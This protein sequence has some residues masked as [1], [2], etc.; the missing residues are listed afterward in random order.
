MFVHLPKKVAV[1]LAAMIITTMSLFIVSCQ[2]EL[3]GGGLIVTEEQPDLS[4]KIASSVSGF[5]TDE[6]DAAVQGATVQFGSNTA[7]TDK[8]GYFEFSNVQVVKNAAVVTV[9]KPG[10]F[11]G[12]K[13]YIAAENKSGFFR[14]KLLPKTTQGSFDA[15]A[16]GTVTLTNGL[17]IAFP[18]AAVKLAAGGTYT[19]QVNVAAQWINPAAN[20]L[21][22]IMPGDLRGLDTDGFLRTLTTYGMAAVELTGSAGELLQIADGKKATMTF[23]IPASLSGAAPAELPLWS[24]DETGGLWKQEGK[25]TKSGSNYV[26]EVSHFSFWNCDVPSNFVQFNCTIK[27]ADGSPVPY[28]LVKVSVVGTQSA[29]YGYTDSSGYTGGAVPNNA[30]LLLEVFPYFNCGTAVYSQNFTTTNTNI[31]LGDL[32]IP[33]SSLATAHVTGTV[34]NC[35]NAPVT[36]GYVIMYS[37]GQYSRYEVDNA[38]AFDFNYTLCSGSIPVSFI[39][40]DAAAN[41]QSTSLSYTLNTGDNAVGNLQACGVTTEQFINYTQ[42][43]VDYSY[44]SPLDSFMQFTNTQSVPSSIFILSQRLAGGQNVNMVSLSFTETGIAAG[45]TQQL[46][47]FGSDSLAISTPVD[48]NITEYGA[49]GQFIAGNFT[50]TLLSPPPGSTPIN[51]TCSFRVRRMQ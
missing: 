8:Y 29:G 6:T 9:L 50:G 23:P 49:V 22:N 7:T 36:D 40:A 15:A 47:S 44:T 38:G 34:T 42:D 13:T 3:S 32:T 5:V 37:N 27:D 16:G 31:S 11:K 24:F 26:G 45:S 4:T 39:A 17:S 46:I 35:A 2:K 12:I 28:V 51:V 14:I 33:A 20:D 1:G 41:E 21:V 43:G 18:A 19:G 48:V 30:Q 10:Y 25:A